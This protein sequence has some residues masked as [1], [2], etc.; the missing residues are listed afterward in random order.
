MTL[1]TLI[2]W[3]HLLAVIAFIGGTIFYF[4][5]YRPASALLKSRPEQVDFTAKIEQRFRTI[6]WLSLV[7]LLITGFF[8]LLYEGGSARIESAYGGVLMLK[9]LLVLVLVAL[10]AVHDFVGGPQERGRSPSGAEA[11]KP[12]AVPAGKPWLGGLILGLSLVIV[13]IAVALVQM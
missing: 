10:T 4:A 1:I 2:M 7:V 5:A 13:L 6:R 12:V 9:L 8:N 11:S 3:I